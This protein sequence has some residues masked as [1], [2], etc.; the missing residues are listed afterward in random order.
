MKPLLRLLL[1]MVTGFFAVQDAQARE[2]S[3]TFINPGAERSGD[4]WELMPRFMKAAADQLDIRLEVVYAN[5]DR[6]RM[7]ELA[8]TIAA[9][10]APPDYVVLVNEKERAP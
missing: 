5:R 4:V 8:R 9:R 1:M 7:V 6:I 2:L 10:P 3:V